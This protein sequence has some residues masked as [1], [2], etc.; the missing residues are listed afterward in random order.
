MNI[1]TCPV[2]SE[3]LYKEGKSYICT[4]RHTFD[5]AKSGYVN[6]LISKQVGKTVHGDNKLMVKARRD[7]LEKGYYGK[8]LAVLSE[9]V[10]EYAENGSIILDSGCGEGYYTKGVYSHLKENGIEADFYG[11]DIS[12]TA[13]EYASKLFKEAH[14]AVGSVFHLPIADKS[15]DIVMTLFAPFCRE[16]FLRVL[17]ESGIFIMVI[18]SVKHLWGLKKAVY[19]TPYLNEVKDYAIDGFE[20]IKSRKI[21]YEINI[22]NNEDIQNLFSMTPYYYRT[23]KIQQER[24]AALNELETEIEFEILVYSAKEN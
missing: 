11:V 9:T 13:L 12:K 19:D 22:D 8:L 6:L 14:F 15:C 1:F 2:C 5:I 7:F 20:L 10:A 21:A 18:P 17:K 16:E 4:K 23:G 3:M 24:L